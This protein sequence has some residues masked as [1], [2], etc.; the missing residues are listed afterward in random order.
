[1][2]TTTFMPLKVVAKD[3][4][5]SNKAYPVEVQPMIS[6]KRLTAYIMEFMATQKSFT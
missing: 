5:V 2:L 3:V 4:A 1:M 6:S